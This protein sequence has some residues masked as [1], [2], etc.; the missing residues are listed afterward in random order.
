MKTT[1]FKTTAVLI[2]LAT[3][4][5]A[6]AETQEHMEK[7]LPGHPGGKLVVDVDFG[8]LEVIGGAGSEVQVDVVRKVT[9]RSKADEQ[10]FLKDRPI[11]ITEEDG[12]ITVR[13]KAKSKINWWRG[14]TK[15]EGKY[16]IL[17]PGQFS[18]NLHT[19]GGSVRVQGLA[20]TV[21]AST[22][23]GQVVVSQITGEVTAKT[24]GGSI[25]A[26][27][28][29]GN[30]KLGTSGGSLGVEGGSGSLAGETSGG[31][32]LVKGF[33]GPVKVSTSGGGISIEEANS[34]VEGSTSGGSVS[35]SL[36]SVPTDSIKLSSSGGSITVRVP[37]QAAFNLDAST[38]AGSV[39]C[40]LPV[41][42]SGKPEKS[43]LVGPV[44]GGG[45]PVHLRTSGG[46]IEIRK[47]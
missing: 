25:R 17:V 26:D 14:T 1:Q 4:G 15:T 5:Y 43:R 12:T 10:A 20:G 27:Q 9:R 37:E 29:K 16:T 7:R 39:R 6:W 35:A 44:N 24:A 36:A 42:V 34:S 32:V 8:A 38:A 11:E 21:D 41:T 40:D 18:S 31:S 45:K 19:A 33:Q 13:S 2:C 30:I 47:L 22:S 28:C 23:G 46:N 3:C